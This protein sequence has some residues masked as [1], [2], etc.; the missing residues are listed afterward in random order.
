MN[1]R[2]LLIFGA[3]L[4]AVAAIIAGVFY[5]ERGSHLILEGQVLKVRTAPLDEK[6]SVLAADFRCTNGADYVFAVGEVKVILTDE[7][8]SP[9][10][11][12]IVAEID[13]RRLFEGIPLLGPKYNDSL[14][15]RDKI[16]AHASLDRMIAAT[17]E[18]PEAQLEKRK[19]LTIRIRE[20]D[21]LVSEFHENR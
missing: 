7:K 4:V 1:S 11:G 19:G 13:A 2:L 15:M 18:M 21:G 16:P 20:L 6:N 14:L 3:A 8:G 10:E 12:A 17:F 5:A 9:V